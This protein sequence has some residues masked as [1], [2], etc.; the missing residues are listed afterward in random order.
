MNFGPTSTLLCIGVCLSSALTFAQGT[1]CSADGAASAQA[2]AIGCVT[3]AGAQI[4][5][6]AAGDTQGP[7]VNALPPD[8]R[9]NLPPVVTF[10]NGRLTIIAKNSTL[11]EVLRAVASKTGAVIDAPEDNSERVVAQLGPGMARD[12]IAA[13]LHGSNFNYVVVGTEQNPSAVARVILTAKTQSSP[14]ADA[15]SNTLARNGVQPRNAL[16]QAVMRPYQEMLRQQ[17]AQAQQT[18][19]AQQAAAEAAQAPA[20]VDP[21]AD[22]PEPPAP[23]A[24]APANTGVESAAV[25]VP[26]PAPNP[27]VQNNNSSGDKSPTQVLQ[28]L[29]ETRRQM[30]Q[31]QR[32]PAPQTQQ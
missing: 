30:I 5:G 22:N 23:V 29:Y 1:T 27:S 3:G 17:Q 28:D 24:S 25:D 9:P 7:D 26:P 31:Q 12:V 4:R 32:Q 16:Q 21:P 19:Q 18:Q 13:L 2:S 14:G 10:E 11:E 6:T 8:Q 15:G 20:V